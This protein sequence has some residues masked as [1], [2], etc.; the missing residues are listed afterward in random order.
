VPVGHERGAFRTAGD[1][2]KLSDGLRFVFAENRDPAGHGPDLLTSTRTICRGSRSLSDA[3][4]ALF[5]V[6]RSKRSAPNDADRLRKYL[7]RF[8]LEWKELRTIANR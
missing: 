6:A 1:I 4:R 5:S 3:G 2:V 8:G 7:A